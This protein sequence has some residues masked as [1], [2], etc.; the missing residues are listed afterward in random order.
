[1]IASAT[2]EGGGRGKDPGDW[3]QVSSSARDSYRLHEALFA[4]PVIFLC[5]SS[6]T[7]NPLGLPNSLSTLRAS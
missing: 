5:P 1:M 3:H 4:L 6:I 2:V 7:P